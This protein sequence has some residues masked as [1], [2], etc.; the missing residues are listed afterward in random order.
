MGVGWLPGEGVAVSSIP[1]AR[2]RD[3]TA[4]RPAGLHPA[5]VVWF[6]NGFYVELKNGAGAPATEVIVDRPGPTGWGRGVHLG[7]HAGVDDVRRATQFWGAA[8][9]YVP[10]AEPE[11][12]WVVLAPE[13]GPGAR[14]ALGKSETPVQEHP[15]VH[16]DLYASD[17]D[18]E[19]ERLLG[20]GAER[21]DWEMYPPDADFIVLAD[22]DGNRF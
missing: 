18:A 11:D 6:D 2:A 10:R 13:K 21:V 3:V 5:E 1:A 12:T 4:T 17:Q 16:L 22:P 9:G 14:L 8:L 20:L 7:L 15:R 19:V